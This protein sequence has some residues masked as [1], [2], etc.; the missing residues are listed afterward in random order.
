VAHPPLVDDDG[1]GKVG[2]FLDRRARK[3]GQPPPGKGAERLDQLPLGFRVDCVKNEGGFP[4]PA[5]ACENDQFVLGNVT[6]DVFEVVRLRPFD[7]DPFVHSAIAA[8]LVVI[9]L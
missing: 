3:F 4:A 1:G 7:N 2:D 5:H 9:N 6:V 8:S